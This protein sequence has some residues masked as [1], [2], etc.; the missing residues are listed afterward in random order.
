MLMTLNGKEVKGQPSIWNQC[1]INLYWSSAD[2]R[3]LLLH[4]CLE[5][6]PHKPSLSSD[7]DMTDRLKNRFMSLDMKCKRVRA[8]HFIN[9]WKK[10]KKGA[11]VSQPHRSLLGVGL[12]KLWL[13]LLRWHIK[14]LYL[15]LS[16]L[17]AIFHFSHIRVAVYQKLFHF[18]LWRKVLIK[19]TPS[20]S[21]SHFIKASLP[22]FHWWK[23]TYPPVKKAK[24]YLTVKVFQLE[25]V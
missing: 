4:F 7:A 12:F 5:T 6:C 3:S 15:W 9:K 13:S 1:N 18:N 8:K 17:T 24:M 25:V 14:V 16:Q 19:G 20:A 2:G 22:S 11:V 23:C 10:K 21:F